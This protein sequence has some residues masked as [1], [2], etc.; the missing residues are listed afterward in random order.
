MLWCQCT[1]KGFRA[2][3]P[4]CWWEVVCVSRAAD[5]I[6]LVTVMGLKSCNPV[7]SPGKGLDGFPRRFPPCAPPNKKSSCEGG[8]LQP[9]IWSRW[10]FGSEDLVRQGHRS[11]MGIHS[12]G[13]T[14]RELPSHL[15]KHTAQLSCVWNNTLHHIRTLMSSVQYI[16]LMKVINI[17]SEKKH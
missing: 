16:Y 13:G 2:E 7:R 9:F 6:I 8:S 10:M 15:P 5:V 3:T 14:K 12:S 11:H 4:V 1:R 17:Q